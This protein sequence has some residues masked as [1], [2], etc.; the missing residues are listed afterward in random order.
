MKFTVRGSFLVF[1][2]LDGN[3][4]VYPENCTDDEEREAICL[5]RWP[6]YPF[7]GMVEKL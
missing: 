5:T 6:Y 3:A 1:C 7:S 4:R 2:S